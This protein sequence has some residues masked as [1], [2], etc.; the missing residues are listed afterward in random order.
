MTL[1]MKAA[2]FFGRSV[3]VYPSSEHTVQVD[4]GLQRNL[5]E[6]LRTSDVLHESG[7][8]KHTFVGKPIVM[9]LN[10]DRMN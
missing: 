7:C 1:N 8:A 4:L 2:Q 3:D 10:Q 9:E 5:R 6:K